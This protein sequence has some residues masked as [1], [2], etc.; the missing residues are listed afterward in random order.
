MYGLNYTL[1]AQEAHETRL[2]SHVT[3][4]TLTHTP[5]MSRIDD[6]QTVPIICRA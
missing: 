4:S 5:F 6:D 1:L 3:L 2:M